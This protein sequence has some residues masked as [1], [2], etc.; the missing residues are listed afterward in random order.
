MECLAAWLSKK[1]VILNKEGSSQ[2]LMSHFSDDANPN[3]QNDTIETD[4]L[5]SYKDRDGPFETQDSQ[6]FVFLEEFLFRL[7]PQVPQ[8]WDYT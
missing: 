3:T 7:F 8:P 6:V 1:T 4:L 2:G 5:I